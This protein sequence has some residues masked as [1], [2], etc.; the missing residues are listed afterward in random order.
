MQF[1]CHY[2][3]LEKCFDEIKIYTMCKTYIKILVL[4]ITFQSNFFAEANPQ[5][6]HHN[7]VHQ[8]KGT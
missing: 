4:L 2:F 8:N 1:V 6:D 7:G 3:A 5:G